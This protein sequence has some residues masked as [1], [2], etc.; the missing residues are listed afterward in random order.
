[1]V[2]SPACSLP[3]SSSRSFL[4]NM[5]RLPCFNSSRRSTV[6]TRGSILFPWRPVISYS[7]YCP[8]FAR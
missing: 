3:S 1:M 2:C 8:C 6:Y 7:L 4:L 5:E